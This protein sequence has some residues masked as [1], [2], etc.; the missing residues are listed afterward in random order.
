MRWPRSRSASSE[1]T[2]LHVLPSPLRLTLSRNCIDNGIAMAT[3]ILTIMAHPDDAEILCGGLLCHL[4]R[5]GWEI[6]LATATAGDCGSSTLP[7][8]EIASIRRQEAETAARRL[9]GRY[10][11][12][13]RRDLLVHYDEEILFDVCGLLRRV[14]PQVVITHS[15][16]DYMADHEEISRVARASCFNAPIPNAPAPEGSRPLE[17]IPWLYY[18]DPVGGIDP[19][20]R[21]IL[22]S[23]LIDIGDVID[24][25]AQLLAAHASQRE[26][27]RAHHRIDEYLES[28]KRWGKERASLVGWEYAEGLRQHLGHAYPTDDILAEVLGP[29]HRLFLPSQERDQV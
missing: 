2:Y 21:A 29:R 23:I 26:W 1:G 10:H 9:G 6:H 22:P 13:E 5:A 28:M 15:P 20:G 16:S 12:L 7:A 8:E 11:C 24:A 4:H 27:L 3:T 14:R 17:A 18:A 25:K 19:L